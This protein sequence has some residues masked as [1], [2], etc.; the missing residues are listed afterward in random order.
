MTLAHQEHVDII[1]LGMQCAIGGMM[2]MFLVFMG[3]ESIMDI[4]IYPKI[5]GLKK[6]HIG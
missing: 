5:C 1:P 3:T 2:R 6:P 4:M